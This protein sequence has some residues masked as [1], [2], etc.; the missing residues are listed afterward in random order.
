VKC[1]MKESQIDKQMVYYVDLESQGIQVGNWL[2]F[3]GN[4]TQAT[5]K[6]L[7]LRHQC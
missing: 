1:M 3:V 2:V 5:G 4:R 6:P 7:G